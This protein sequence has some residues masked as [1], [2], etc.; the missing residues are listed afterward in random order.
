VDAIVDAHLH[1]F[2]RPHFEALAAE[3]TTPGG[4]EQRL[5]RLEK[6]AG[7]E[8]PPADL[9]KH[10]TRWLQAL[11]ENAVTHAV[12]FASSA[13][14]AEAV[15]FA[16]AVSGGRL[17][18]VAA[19]NPKAP[20]EV[21]RVRGLL[22]RQGYRGVLLFPALHPYRLGDPECREVVKAVAEAGG[23][24]YVQCGL[25]KVPLRD[26]LGLPR[27]V[28]VS[29]ANPLDVIPL[30]DAFPRTTFVIPHL[31]AGFLRE[32]LMAGVQCANVVVDTSSS[33]SWLA[34]SPGGGTLGET[35]RRAIAA[36]GPERILFG[37]DSST[38]PR[39][40]RGDLLVA[41]RRAF[42]EA[43]LSSEGFALVFG[44]NAA[45]IFGIA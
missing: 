18:P 35:F 32:A 23:V 3:A 9:A 5:A 31:G 15:S 20:G 11:D 43:G 16:A 40:W 21:D 6:E 37:T 39:G 17:V 30:A 10:V 25:L 45:R 4:V 12:T 29:R 13:A 1:L 42:M 41:H 34:T 28:D 24:V 26:R 7:I 44:G 36:L 14:E 19:S 27:A 8:V 2:S 38:F 33:N 22:G